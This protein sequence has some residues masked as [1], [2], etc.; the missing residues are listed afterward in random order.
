M[1]AMVVA[2]ALECRKAAVAAKVTSL[3]MPSQ[4]F[5]NDDPREN[6]AIIAG[7]ALAPQAVCRRGMGG[8]YGGSGLLL[9]LA[10]VECSRDK[11]YH[12]L[13]KVIYMY[14]FALTPLPR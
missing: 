9:R 6:V 1:M 7:L 2:A 13:Q 10:R 8:V 12:N 3:M 4:V 14:D 11:I 5:K